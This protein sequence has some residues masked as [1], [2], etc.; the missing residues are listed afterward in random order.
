MKNIKSI[1]ICAASG[2]ILSL[3]CGFFSKAGFGHIFLTALIF[4]IVFGLLG[5]GISFLF[6]RFLSVEAVQVEAADSSN[7]DVNFDVRSSLTGK[8]PDAGKRLKAG[9]GGNTGWNV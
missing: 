7:N 6:D 4:G 2:F 9:E 5:F 1:A 8:D 3:I